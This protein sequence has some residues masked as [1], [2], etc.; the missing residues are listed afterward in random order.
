DT[1][2]EVPCWLPGT[3]TA[4]VPTSLGPCCTKSASDGCAGQSSAAAI[5]AR[6]PPRPGR[7]P[8]RQ[9]KANERTSSTMARPQVAGAHEIVTAIGCPRS[10]Q[11][12]QSHRLR[13][14]SFSAACLVGGS[15]F[16]PSILFFSAIDL[17][18]R[19][20][21]WDWLDAQSQPLRN[22]GMQRNIALSQ[23]A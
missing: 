7:T 5:T 18:L 13:V 4:P 22:S 12:A 20:T 1:A 2:T 8:R 21:L 15:F 6:A 16:Q 14:K 19:A 3:P 9:L 23:Q 10:L 17:L 11:P